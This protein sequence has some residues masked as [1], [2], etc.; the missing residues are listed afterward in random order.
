MNT[1]EQTLA[2]SAIYIYIE[3]IELKYE[4]LCELN[5]YPI[6]KVALNRL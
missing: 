6:A 3:I 4:N 1:M 5:A 2:L